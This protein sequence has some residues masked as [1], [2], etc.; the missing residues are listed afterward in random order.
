M[1]LTPEEHVRVEAAIQRWVDSSIS[2]TANLPADYT[3]E[4]TREAIRR[5]G[6][7]AKVELSGG[8][9]L[10]RMAE[11]AST[12]ADYVSIGA[13][14]HSAPSIDLSFEMEPDA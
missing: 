12:G 10:E 14:T 8:V 6:G 3:I 2:K 4:Q 5:T 9:S 13:L 7:R 11:L 1:D